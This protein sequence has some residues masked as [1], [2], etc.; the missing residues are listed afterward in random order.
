[1]TTRRQIT[2]CLALGVAAFVA[3]P[4]TYLG[5][6]NPRPADTQASSDQKRPIR[7]LRD[8][9]PVPSF[10]ARDLDGRP[11]SP[12]QWR[13]KVVLVNFWATWC[14]PCRAEIP[15][16]VAL[17]DK[18]RGRLQIIGV[19]EDEG[20]PESVRQFATEFKI[21][22][23]IVMATPEVRKG[24][25]TVFGLPTTFMLDR[26][27]RIVQKHIGLVNAAGIEDEI[28]ALAGLPVNAVVERVEDS[29]QVRLENAAQA[30]TI[31]GIDLGQVPAARKAA[32]LQALNT[33][34][35]TC[36]CGLTV[37]QCRINDASCKFSLPLAQTIVQRFS[38]RR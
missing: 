4:V 23:P 27:T 29:G 34:R 24:F 16:L 32:A 12:V 11:V 7:F 19:S 38:D 1:M 37:A 33:E 30:T 31:P 22:Y 6:F 21:N 28:R 26:D 8:P 9:V 13:G 35:C 5:A 36:G 18:Y 17:Q 14:L 15:A 10:A 2:L 3:N 25:P 20:S